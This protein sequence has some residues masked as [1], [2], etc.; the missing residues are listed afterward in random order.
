MYI[1]PNFSSSLS[2]RTHIHT[3]TRGVFSNLKDSGFFESTGAKAGEQVAFTLTIAGEGVSDIDWILGKVISYDHETQ[4]YHI[5]DEDM[6]IPT[7]TYVLAES[8]IQILGNF[9][10]LSKGDRVWAVYPDTT[11]F[12]QAT[13]V[14]VRKTQGGG[15]SSIAY[16]NFL[17][18]HDEMGVT[19]DKQVLINHIM[20][21]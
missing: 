1:H 6:E 5:A 11:S 15:S 19:H 16:V 4:V 21:I 7:K 14:T 8:Q 9:E 20:K 10:K 18:D 2:L 12:Y 13:V 17:D 3:H